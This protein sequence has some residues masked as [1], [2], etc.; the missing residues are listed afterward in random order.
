MAEIIG[1]ITRNSTQLPEGLELIAPGVGI[2]WS[3]DGGSFS[4]VIEHRNDSG[5]ALVFG[6]HPAIPEQV[7]RWASLLLQSATVGNPLSTLQSGP[8]LLHSGLAYSYEHRTLTLVSGR[9]GLFPVYLVET[10][11]ALWFTSHPGLLLGRMELEPD[12]AGL[13]QLLQYG[14]CLGR[15]TASK[16]VMVLE[17]TEVVRYRSGEQLEWLG[18]FSDP[19]SKQNPTQ[20]TKTLYPAI[21]E[22]LKQVVQNCILGEDAW[23]QATGGLDSRL[24]LAAAQDVP[25]SMMTFGSPESS[26]VKIAVELA[27]I[28]QRP[29][30]HLNT[31][32]PETALDGWA[33]RVILCSG[34]EKP[35]D[36][37]HTA[38][39][40]QTYEQYPGRVLINGNGGEFA[41]AYWYDL[42]LLGYG[43]NVSL[44]GGLGNPLM[45]RYIERRMAG[46]SG[47]A[48][49]A[50]L[51]PEIQRTLP[52][53]PSQALEEAVRPYTGSHSL[54]ALLD[55]FYLEVRN[56]RFVMLGLQLGGLFFNRA[57]P[58]FDP[59]LHDLLTGLPLSHRL[60]SHFHRQAIATLYP[61]LSRVIWDKT[62]RP[63]DEGISSFNWIPDHWRLDTHQSRYKSV[64]Y[65]DYAFLFRTQWRNWFIDTTATVATALDTWIPAQK[66]IQMRDEH[67]AGLQDHTRAWGVLLAYG[68]W[69]NRISKSSRV[70]TSISRF[71]D[72]L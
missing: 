45:L 47:S 11:R 70:V 27:C 12:P 1:C 29:F 56:H 36:N 16:G 37:A 30:I 71:G 18:R 8:K 43:F 49:F 33:E 67:L 60:G 66:L 42:G 61:E 21:E 9:F 22:R 53:K 58:F 63:L 28:S 32:I 26:D 15:T 50:L 35:L 57:H 55:D 3:A 19:V 54:A 62:G 17:P 24:L 39:P 34:G 6:G 5:Y 59:E 13:A 46:R 64:P 68:L 10:S 31:S 7:S 14:H 72:D 40:Y 52:I 23:L 4:D 41:R 65:V 44:P 2:L 38:L 48:L 25:A 69:V 51:R 20:K